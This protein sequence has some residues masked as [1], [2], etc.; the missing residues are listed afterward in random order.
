M[1]KSRSVSTKPIVLSE[2]E[3]HILNIIRKNTS[4]SV[5]D[6][7]D[8]LNSKLDYLVVLRT[9]HGLVKKSLLIQI[10]SGGESLYQPRLHAIAKLRRMERRMLGTRNEA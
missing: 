10:I 8:F 7:S 2:S 4:C 5:Q 1:S 3:I 6:V 9:I